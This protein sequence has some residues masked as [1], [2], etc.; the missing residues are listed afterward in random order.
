MTAPKPLTRLVSVDRLPAPG[1][2][3]VVESTEEERAALARDFGLPGIASLTGR[4][5]ITGGLKRAHVQGEVAAKVTRTC[6][7]TLDPF[8]EEVR[9]PVDLEFTEETREPG[10]Q[11]EMREIDPPDEI[12]AGKI[13]LG[14]VTAEFL[15]LGLDPHP[16]KPGASFGEAESDASATSPFAALEKLKGKT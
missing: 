5:K 15:A 16:R 2:E 3:I 11:A 12:V 14:A 13:D 7:V 1:R 10:Q 6:V 8:E 9:E 4:F